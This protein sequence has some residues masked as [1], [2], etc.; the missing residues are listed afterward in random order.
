MTIFEN[1]ASKSL[2]EMVSVSM[3]YNKYT[4]YENKP[5][6]QDNDNGTC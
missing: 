3:K 5:K 1:V 2:G 4:S 6:F